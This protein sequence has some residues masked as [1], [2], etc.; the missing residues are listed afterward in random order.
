MLLTSRYNIME[1][2]LI[3]FLQLAD[4]SAITSFYTEFIKSVMEG[5]KVVLHGKSEEQLRLL[6]TKIGSLKMLQVSTQEAKLPSTLLMLNM[7]MI[8]FIL[9]Q[10][11]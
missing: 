7:F 11:I 8:M 9:F 5:I 6:V 1:K 10:C 4:L 3:P 2:V